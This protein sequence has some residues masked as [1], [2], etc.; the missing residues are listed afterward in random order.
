MEK[1]FKVLASLLK[2][3]NRMKLKTPFLALLVAVFTILVFQNCSKVKY[4]FDIGAVAESMKFED[5]QVFDGKIRILHHYVD[6]FT[7]N[8]NPAPESILIRTAE[9]DWYLIQNTPQRCDSEVAVAV[10]GVNYDEAGKMATYQNKV[11]VPPRPYFVDASAD[12]NLSDANLMD[13]V[14]ASQNGQCTLRAAVEQGTVVSFTDA[15]LIHI[16]RGT[17]TLT[18]PLSLTGVRPESH[19]ITIRGQDPVSSVLD[20]GGVSRHFN[21]R[22][23]SMSPISIENLT[24]QNGRAGGGSTWGSSILFFLDISILASYH[25]SGQY[26]AQVL[27]NN[28][29]HYFPQYDESTANPLKAQL[30]IDNCIFKGNQDGDVIH[31]RPL[32]GNLTIRGSLF[33]QNYFHGVH[34]NGA[35]SLVIEDSIFN[36]PQGHYG[37]SIDDNFSHASIKRSKFYEN[38]KGIGFLNCRNC[39]LESIQSY[40]QR[41]AGLEILT[42]EAD[43]RFNVTARDV[44]IYDNRLSSNPH[45]ADTGNLILVFASSANQINFIDSQLSMMSPE[46]PNCASVSTVSQILMTSTTVSDL[47]CEP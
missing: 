43:A 39:S 5:G 44:K 35:N 10:E 28:M 37:V 36:N 6:N 20:G 46:I 16:P 30:D 41:E 15:V 14:C 21:I 26:R 3:M 18:S 47:S 23:T 27:M 9:L 45:A 24:L 2:S 7:C 34:S 4:A 42:T 11:Y 38:Y 17:F 8:G 1:D 22:S 33:T 32:T 31:A 40:H 12:P 29:A 19:A 25:S 13:G